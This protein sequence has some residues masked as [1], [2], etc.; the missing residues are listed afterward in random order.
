MTSKFII[1]LGWLFFPHT[2]YLSNFFA[3]LNRWKFLRYYATIKF[4]PVLQHTNLVLCS[5]NPVLAGKITSVQAKH[6][7]RQGQLGKNHWISSYFGAFVVLF[8]IY[9]TI[10]VLFLGLMQQICNNN[11][12]KAYI[13]SQCLWRISSMF[14]GSNSLLWIHGNTNPIQTPNFQFFDLISSPPFPKSHSC[15]WQKKKEQVSK[16][17]FGNPRRL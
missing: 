1:N 9:A 3:Q 6:C 11:C 5:G 16:A 15:I 17:S 2:S 7:H 14:L 12:N 4:C 8:C 13:P 10:K